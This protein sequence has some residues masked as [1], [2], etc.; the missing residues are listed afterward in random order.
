MCA[1]RS[2]WLP[3]LWAKRMSLSIY[4][5]KGP[6]RESLKGINVHAWHQGVRGKIDRRT[7]SN[8]W[9]RNPQ[10]KRRCRKKQ[11]NKV[12]R[13]GMTLN[14][15]M[16]LILRLRWWWNTTLR[17]KMTTSLVLEKE[18]SCSALTCRVTGLLLRILRLVEPELYPEPTSNLSRNGEG[19]RMQ[20]SDSSAC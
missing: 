18:K 3:L 16:R 4:F 13:T 20:K 12:Y 15:E 9:Q 7:A 17:Q 11:S 1:Q 10:Q 5:L 8:L 2:R 14:L 19:E 6:N